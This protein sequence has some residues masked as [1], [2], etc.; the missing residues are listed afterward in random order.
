M[1]VI[2]S[3]EPEFL[4]QMLAYISGAMGEDLVFHGSFEDAFDVLNEVS[5]DMK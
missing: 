5:I 2:L 1:E 3:K 4:A